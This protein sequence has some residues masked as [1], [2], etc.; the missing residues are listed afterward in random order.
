MRKRTLVDP[1]NHKHSLLDNHLLK[2]E[3]MLAGFPLLKDLFLSKS[4]FP[5]N[6]VV[7]SWTVAVPYLFLVDSRLVSGSCFMPHLSPREH[8][9]FVVPCTHS[10]LFL[11]PLPLDV[12][13]AAAAPQTGFTN[14]L[15]RV[16]N[17]LFQVS[18]HH[19]FRSG[20]VSRFTFLNSIL[21]VQ[22]QKWL[23]LLW[24]LKLTVIEIFQNF[25]AN[26]LLHRDFDVIP[27]CFER[28]YIVIP[29]VD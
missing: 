15:S 16:T 6:S 23:E 9:P 28:L 20:V 11:F 18:D 1:S 8:W 13:L 17:F 24:L 19:I 7:E 29:Q 2:R 27:S 25:L 14:C 3:S 22:G 5:R 4:L 10:P 26:L 21:N 12:S